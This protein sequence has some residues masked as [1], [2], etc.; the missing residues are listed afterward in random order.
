MVGV[1][2]PWVVA[3]YIISPPTRTDNQT[4]TIVASVGIGLMWGKV[5][6]EPFAK[7]ARLLRTYSA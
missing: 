3:A 5:I 6:S 7:L 1:M 2:A 4:F